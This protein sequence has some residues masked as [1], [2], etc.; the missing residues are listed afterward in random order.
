MPNLQ[1]TIGATSIDST[2]SVGRGLEQ[3]ASLGI[4]KVSRMRKE[5]LAEQAR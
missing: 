1:R 3:I 5:A 4:E 2:E